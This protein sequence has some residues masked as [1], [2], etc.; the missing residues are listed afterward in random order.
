M[1]S[2][3]KSEFD[4][5]LWAKLLKS[6]EQNKSLT[7]IQIAKQFGISNRLAYAYYFALKNKG[8]INSDYKISRTLGKARNSIREL[9]KSNTSLLS[10]NE[11][12]QD[13]INFLEAI[14]MVDNNPSLLKPIKVSAAGRG[15]DENTAISL[16]GDVHV[17][18]K[19]DPAVVRGL[20]EY[21]PEIAE[22]RM[23]LYFKR[24][25]WMIESLR[26]GGWKINTLVL[27]ILGDVIN[28]YIHEEF[29][30]DNF[31]SPTEATLFI[32]ELITKGI[33]FLSDNGKFKTIKVICK[34]GNHGRTTKKKHHSTGYK[35]S[36][37]WMMYTQIK[38]NFEEYIKRN[39]VEVIVERG[40]FTTVEVY[41][42][43]LCFSH[44]DHFNYQGG[45]GGMLVP[46]NRWLY[47]MENVIG[48]DRYYI[49]H[50]HQLM[51]T[52]RGVVNGSVVGYNAYAMEYGFEPE[53]PQQFL[54]LIDSRRGFT[55]ETPIILE[56]WK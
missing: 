49:G 25:L 3:N 31:K 46:F 28:G 30:E 7:V 52:K 39:N 35:N 40:T 26:Q 16:L 34:Y 47:K 6:V 44:G 56:D 29:I 54:G 41:D 2:N 5:L 20:N 38:K 19:V 42:K 45:I 33:I 22:K 50:W 12:L 13:K 9:R 23:E 8:I 43:L 17:E 36:Y 21:N 37:E 51:Q 27:A 48:A 14:D 24:L 53:I 15:V 10:E 1:K 11:L 18:A 4:L 32:Q 55:V